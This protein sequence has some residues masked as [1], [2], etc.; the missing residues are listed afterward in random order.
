[1]KTIVLG[2]LTMLV[3]LNPALARTHGHERVGRAHARGAAGGTPIIAGD[4][5]VRI[6]AMGQ[7]V[8]SPAPMIQKERSFDAKAQ[9]ELSTMQQTTPQPVQP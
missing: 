7:V 4:D 1:M 6:D 2:A 3:F 9:R 5:S 8:S